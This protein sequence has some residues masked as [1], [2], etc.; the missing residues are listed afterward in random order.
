MKPAVGIKRLT[1]CTK[2]LAT[3][4]HL[5]G[6]KD[7]LSA[8]GYRWSLHRC[9][10]RVPRQASFFI[11]ELNLAL[12]SPAGRIHHLFARL[13]HGGPAVLQ[14]TSAYGVYNTQQA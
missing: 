12:I 8:S 14:H 3:V 5:Q 2:D 6:I 13:G 11:D 9:A 4:Q 10:S 1:L 7:Y